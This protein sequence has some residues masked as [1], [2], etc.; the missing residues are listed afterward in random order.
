MLVMEDIHVQYCHLVGRFLEHLTKLI[1]KLHMLVGPVF[2]VL[3]IQRQL[4]GDRNRSS[5]K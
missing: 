2:V 4:Q 3:I 5:L 1:W